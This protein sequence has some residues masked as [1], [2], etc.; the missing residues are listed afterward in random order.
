MLE[1][2]GMGRHEYPVLRAAKSFENSLAGDCIAAL[3]GICI[4][5]P[6]QKGVMIGVFWAL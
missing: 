6:G 4:A 1:P 2:N 3:C 5:Y